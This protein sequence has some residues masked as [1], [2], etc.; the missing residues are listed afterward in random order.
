LK[1]TALLV[2]LA[3]IAGCKR[4]P[5][6]VRKPQVPRGPGIVV[7]AA[8]GDIS[9]EGIEMQEATARLVLGG[10]YDAVLLLGDNQYPSGSLETYQR[11]FQPTWG[12]FKEKIHPAPGNH[13]YRTPGAKGY[14][15]YF[16]AR[17]GD[18]KK[19][20]YSFDLGSWHLIA[21]NSSDACR[22]VPC[23]EGSEQLQWLKDDLEASDKKC[24]LAFWHHPRFSSGPH[25]DFAGLSA[26][27]NTLEAH[28][29]ELVLSGHDHIYE[30]FA[31][32]SADGTESADGGIVSFVAGTG[33]AP[34]YQL[35][36]RRK[37]SVVAS[38]ST[39]GILALSLAADTYAWDFVSVDPSSALTDRGT[40]HCH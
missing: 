1:R 25:G 9:P 8:A 36:T 15:D 27:W 37:S 4:A 5:L 38:A 32:L 40:G 24:T 11:Y 17:A 20:Y 28:G 34:I 29:V 2:L 35:G 30:R 22:T 31:P 33:G 3:F 26:V 6:G 16:G 23:G 19:G 12:R 14:F 13:E 21:L 18:P 7:V 39:H 10:D